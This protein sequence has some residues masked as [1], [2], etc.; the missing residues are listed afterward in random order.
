MSLLGVLG[1]LLGGGQNKTLVGKVMDLVNSP[2]V[3]GLAGIVG[4][5]ESSGLTK[6]VQS[7]VSTGTN[8]PATGQDIEKGLGIEKIAALAQSVG[9]TPDV[10]KGKLATI[11]PQV[12]DK[13]TPDGVIP[14]Q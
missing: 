12:I 2:E 8:L 5:F 13:L 6:Q 10:L 3:G 7:W 9:L 1:G 14:K 11:L 4:A